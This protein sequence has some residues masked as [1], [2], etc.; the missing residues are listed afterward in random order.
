MKCPGQ[1]MQFWNEAA[2][3]E[4]PCSKCGQNIEFYKDDTNRKCSHCGNRM[5]N[6]RMDF[7]CASYCQY[8]EQCLGALPEEFLGNRDN[9]L[10]DRVAVEVKR[11]LKADFKRIGYAIKVA[12]HAEKIGREE[13]GNIAAAVCA[14]YLLAAGEV[15][16]FNTHGDM[17]AEH[18]GQEAKKLTET[19]L[20]RLAANESIIEDVSGLIACTLT[21]QDAAHP[22]FKILAD[23]R[24]LAG[25]EDENKQ[26][27]LTTD[28]VQEA[29]DHVLLTASGRQFA[30]KMFK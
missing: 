26:S 14:A 30:E 2:I 11:Y 17:T 22:G 13:G 23:A 25:L 24:T 9:L 7:G 16:A 8:A 12:Q 21:P 29:I 5:V 27:P 20:T 10:K 3:F 18:I 28:R 15:E 6:P 1:D 4:A 19:I